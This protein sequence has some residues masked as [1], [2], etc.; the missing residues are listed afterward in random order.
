MI[1][2]RVV[3]DEHSFFW[4]ALVQWKVIKFGER[5]GDIFSVTSQIPST[6]TPAMCCQ[7][8]LMF[9]VYFLNKR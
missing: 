8:I 9:W 2:R 5:L 4:S 6:D 3:L 7:A 1:C